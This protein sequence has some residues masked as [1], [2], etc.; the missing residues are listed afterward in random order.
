MKR[1][2]LD[3]DDRFANVLTVTLVGHSVHWDAL[4]GEL[5]VTT[6]SFDIT[7]CDHITVDEYGKFTQ[8]V[9]DENS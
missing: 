9:Q 7:K 2:I 5:H 6:S 3:I 4:K 8:E 1:V